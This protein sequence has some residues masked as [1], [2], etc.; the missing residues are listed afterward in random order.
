MNA[1]PQRAFLSAGLMLAAMATA[2]HAQAQVTYDLTGATVASGPLGQ[3]GTN[4]GATTP[5]DSYFL[6][7]GLTKYQQGQG[8][9]STGCADGIYG[10]ISA[11]ADGSLRY[12]L[13]DTP[14]G[15]VKA[16]IPTSSHTSAEVDHQAFIH[17]LAYSGLYTNFTDPAN[18][19]VSFT[20]SGHSA[21]AGQGVQIEL[22]LNSMAAPYTSL[23]S[24]TVTSN[25]AGDWQLVI[26]TPVGEDLFGKSLSFTIGAASGT[27]T[28]SS[29][30]ITPHLAAV[31]EPG[32]MM[33][34]GLGLTGLVWRRRHH[35]Q[36]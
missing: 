3:I 21:A 25:S 7:L 8:C 12:D 31:P 4:V 26:D 6:M 2:N 15:T 18:T 33:L 17:G 34:M 13:K 10:S 30:L 24:Q 23:F 11:T 22:G 32:T 27:N 28:L 36:A 35:R 9:E 1:F 14:V 29:L 19:A 5:D 16:M 20:F